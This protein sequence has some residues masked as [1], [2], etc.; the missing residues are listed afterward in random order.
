MD[1]IG[2]RSL[3]SLLKPAVIKLIKLIWKHHPHRSKKRKKKV[4]LNSSFQS[5]LLNLNLMKTDRFSVAKYIFHCCLSS[6]A[7]L[8]LALGVRWS[9]SRN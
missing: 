4:L 3:H 8:N 7:F 1:G 5:W 9:E 2:P 6:L